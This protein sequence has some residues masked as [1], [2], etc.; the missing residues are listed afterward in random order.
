MHARSPES[1]ALGSRAGS[2]PPPQP[3]AGPCIPG[4]TFQLAADLRAR[5]VNESHELCA[6]Q[7]EYE[8]YH[9]TCG[10][11]WLT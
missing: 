5:L 6:S 9:T 4:P 3:A 8:V 7:E 2:A 11:T 10:P 1:H